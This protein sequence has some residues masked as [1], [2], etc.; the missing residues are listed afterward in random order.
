MQTEILQV[1]LLSLMEAPYNPRR[2][3]SDAGMEELTASVERHGV[4]VPLLVRAVSLADCPEREGYGYYEIIAGARRFRAAQAAMLESVPVRVLELS[5]DEALELA[6][7]EN[8]TREDVHP[9]DEAA[10]FQAL[11]QRP[12]YDVAA[13]AARVSKSESYVYQRLQLLKLIPIAQEAFLADRIHAGHALL[14]SRLQ[15]KDQE[16]ALER[17]YDRYGNERVLVGVRQLAAWIQSNIYLDLHSAPFKKDD[18]TLL[19]AAGSCVAC[20]KRSGYAPALFADIHKAD[21]CTDPTCFQ[22]KIQAHIKVTQRNARAA[23]E[24]LLMVSTTW[25]RPYNQKAKKDDPIYRT[26]WKPVE[27]KKDRCSFTRQALV[28]DGTH[29]IGRI[30]QVC[31]DPACKK[32]HGNSS[33]RQQ[34]DPEEIAKEKKEQ[35]RRELEIKIR[36]GVMDAILATIRTDYCSREEWAFILSAVVD[37]MSN[38]S[39]R[40]LCR[41]HDLKPGED[42]DYP[43]WRTIAANWV[44]GIPTI[45]ELRSLAMEIALLPLT[46]VGY[47]ERY[48][49]RPDPLLKA[50]DMFSVDV[51][52]VE[53]TI[54]IGAAVQAKHAKAKTTK[55]RKAK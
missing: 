12:G 51:Q 49:D 18:E 23:G 3:F 42:N 43:R 16:E 34:R 47:H 2:R 31:A 40:I 30:L 37:L 38:D 19:P 24:D 20:P 1:N 36:T 27:K 44:K 25:S 46:M 11:L 33:T 45:V 8:L 28:V 41:R 55:K 39:A 6:I 21:T 10:G 9:M 22:A 14:I 26:S 35:A 17:A 53:D 32:H 29:D 13:V 50:A 48:D 15:P 54:K 52:H 4:L 7:L 5:D